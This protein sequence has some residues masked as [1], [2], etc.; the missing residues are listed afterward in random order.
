[1]RSLRTKITIFTVFAIVVAITSVSVIGVIATT[2]IGTRGTDQ[3][4]YLMCQ[5]GKK[6][7]DYYFDSVSRAVDDVSTFIKADL[8]ITDMENFSGHIDR[9]RTFFDKMAHKTNGVLT[10]YYRIDPTVS[11]TEK[12]FWYIDLDG[13]GF[14]EH[15][16]TDITMYDTSDTSKLVWFTV[17][18]NT[19]NPI[20]LSPYITDNLDVRVISYNTPVYRKGVFIGVVGIE[21]D[22]STLASQVNNIELY[23]SG[24]AFINEDDGTIVYHPKIDV[25]VMA[26]EDIPKVPDG[27]LG[28]DKKE[29][30]GMFV[31]YTFEGIKRE[32]VWMTLHN[33][34][35]LN[36]CVSEEEING[37]TVRV[38]WLIV[39]ISA[40]ILIVFVFLAFRL[41][42]QITKPLKDLTETADRLEKG[43]YDVKFDYSGSTTEISVLTR[44][45]NKLITH[46]KSYI[47]DL[48]SLAYGDALTH[49]KNKGAYDIY[50]RE[51]QEQLDKAEGKAEF[52]IIML[53]CDGLKDINDLYGHEKGDIYIKNSCHLI[54]RVFQYSPVFRIGGD[55]F[56]VIL[57]EEDYLA[58]EDLERVFIEKSEEICALS[59]HPWEEINVSLGMAVYDP[60]T[61]K[62]VRDVIH[63]ADLLMYTD[64][65]ERKAMKGMQQQ[66][67]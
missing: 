41:T 53:D 20:W 1:M 49:V 29:D 2:R 52:A 7:L 66:E 10:Y 19:G 58:R 24:Y 61:D 48:N 47:N 33:G 14:K 57:K 55:E 39:I 32:A 64:K 50:I 15:E 65:Y 21:I 43:D 62:N 38:T 17:P 11:T 36:V 56:V 25:T 3:L 40:V 59:E 44:T 23:K 22:Y 16:V 67:Q 6:N 31:T 45:V 27:L 51:L 35:R 63:R 18:K 46:L 42:G 54:C 12:G 28:T 13:T 34:M 5:T 8:D 4:L 37:E 30:E 60:N 9:A 26:P